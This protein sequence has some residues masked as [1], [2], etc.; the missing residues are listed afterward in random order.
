MS[1]GNPHTWKSATWTPGKFSTSTIS[2]PYSYHIGVSCSLCLN[3]NP[4]NSETF[5]SEHFFRTYFVLLVGIL[6]ICGRGLNLGLF[7]LGF[8]DFSVRLISGPFFF[9]GFWGFIG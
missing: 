5:M 2:L 1:F 6:G 9:Q 7:L 3:P 4:S 8:G